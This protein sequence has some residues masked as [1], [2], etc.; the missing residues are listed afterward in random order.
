MI[1]FWVPDSIPKGGT[2]AQ[3]R[4]YLSDEKVAMLR[5]VGIN[6]IREFAEADKYKILKLRGFD[7]PQVRRTCPQREFHFDAVEADGP[8]LRLAS[9]G[10][11]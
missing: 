11:A 3:V 8:L 4:Q 1:R 9:L 5:S 10:G 2:R 6:T 7:I